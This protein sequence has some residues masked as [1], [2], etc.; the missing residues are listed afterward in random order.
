MTDDQTADFAQLL[1]RARRD[2]GLSQEELAERA[3]LS[4]RAISALERGVN[5]APRRDTLDMLADALGLDAA[6][7]RRWERL[8]REQSVRSG[9]ARDTVPTPSAALSGTLTFLFTDIDASTDWSQRF[10]SQMPE[11]LE[12]YAV[13]L[14]SAIGS[15][16]GTVFKTIGDAICAA[17]PTAPAALEAALIAQ[18]AIVAEDWGEVGPIR[19]RMALHSGQADLR[20]NAYVGLPLNL[21]TRILAAGHGGQMLLSLATQQ[22]VRDHLPSGVHLRDLGDGGLR[23]LLRREHLFQVVAPDLP[24]DFPP[25]RDLDS[26]DIELLAGATRPAARNPYKGLRAFQESDSDDFFG[27]EVLTQRLLD[28]LAEQVPLRR[29]MVVVGPSGSGKSSVVRAGLL[30]LLKRGALPGSERW[31]VV[32]II[33]GAHPVEELEAALLRICVNPPP[34]LLDQLLADERGLLRTAKRAL[35]EDE[36]VEL[37]VVIDQFEEVFTLIPDEPARVHFLESLSVAVRDPRSRVRVV[38]TLRADFY[39]RPLLYPDPGEMVRQRTEVVLPLTTEELH[40]AIVGPAQRVGVEVEPELLAAII[41]DVG[42]QPGTLP[43]LQYALTE[44]FERRESNLLTLAVYQQAG[45]L[46]GAVSRRAEDLYASLTLAEQEVVRQVFLRLIVLGEGQEDT[47]RR[48]RL[49]ELRSLDVPSEM[50]EGV[51]E[52]FGTARLLTFDRD[53]ATGEGTVEVAHEALLRTWERLRGWLEHDRANLR[54]HRQ[55]A[56]ATAEWE[57]SGRDPSFLATGTRLSLLEALADSDIALTEEERDYLAASLADREREE[58][59]ERD[60]QDQELALAQRAAR[61]QRSAAKRLRFLAGA[62]AVFLVVVAALAALSL[63]S[64]GDALDSR[65]DALD[66]FNQSESQRLAAEASGVLQQGKS[67]ELAALLALRGLDAAYTGAADAALQ[68]A[69][70]LDYGERIFP[71]P[72]PVPR[73]TFSPD[74]MYLVTGV[75][76]SD[77]AVIWNTTTGEQIYRL[78]GH[79][80]GVPIATFSSDGRYVVTGSVNS[81][82][83]KLWDMMTGQELHQFTVTDTDEE[84]NEFPS[85]FAAVFAPDGETLLLCCKGVAVHTW[86]VQTGEERSAVVLGID[87]EDIYRANFSPDGRS[88]LVGSFDG[89][90]HLLD[91][92]SGELLQTF[93]GHDL[94]VTDMEFAPDGRQVLT[95]SWDSTIRL[96]DVQTGQ[97]VRQFL[98]H[99]EIVSDIAFSADGTRILSGA[100]D[101][102]ARVWDVA[103]GDEILRITGHTAAVF[104]VTFAPDGRHIATG[105]LDQTARLWDIAVPAAR[106][107]LSGHSDWIYG[108]AFSPDGSRLVSGSADGTAR[109]W[110]VASGALLLTIEQPSGVTDADFSPDGRMIVTAAFDDAVRLWDAETGALLR[111]L[112]GYVQALVAFTPDGRYLLVSGGEEGTSVWDVASWEQVLEFPLGGFFS[113]SPDGRSVATSG[114]DHVVVWEVDTGRELTRI[115]SEPI[116][117]FPAFSPDG[118][119]LLTGTNENT[120]ILWDIQSGERLRTFTGHT[121]LVLEVAF[122]ADG[123]YVLTSGEDKTARLWETATGRQV[124]TFAGYGNTISAIAVSPDGRHVA[125]ADSDGAVQLA[126]LDLDELIQSVCGRVLR[127]FTPEERIVYSIEG[128]QPTCTDDHNQP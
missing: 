110:D 9:E 33:P 88:L 113:V 51:L 5:R 123:R 4:A 105:S 55:L 67:G 22:L 119:Q 35:P 43:L 96:W 87:A 45:G 62:M 18:R 48:V 103:S 104:S 28:R 11:I 78:A 117:Y 127:D 71:L 84:A 2:V 72:G 95:S 37:L 100:D 83:V 94:A 80:G 89:T 101:T 98:G 63:R 77:E 126:T 73:V 25:L 20:E 76:R 14:Q 34:S 108:V 26:T 29:F 8:R 125:I 40:R 92:A 41:R 7:R 19:V 90:T 93:G 24:A 27:R 47:R 109:L 42:E 23:G 64:R 91:A 54:L 52:L 82:I 118:T 3:G 124:R 6:E 59:L 79:G 21:V 31:V 60:R 15:C 16:G 17:F 53:A 57:Q 13:I 36:A 70:R 106:D 114:P 30:P 121:N 85:L 111:E 58:E 74:G 68:R 65:G 56:D 69:A 112:P 122:S 115:G 39:D 50:L 97:E 128:D 66:S 99:T 81:G 1:R 107:T 46:L 120:A 102:T 116:Y 32:H 12:R 10:P 49:S 38:C 61:A 86:D 75:G 44:L